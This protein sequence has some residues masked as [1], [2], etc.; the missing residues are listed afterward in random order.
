[1]GKA[2]SG[3]STLLKSLLRSFR[4][5]YQVMGIAEMFDKGGLSST[6]SIVNPG[7][8]RRLKRLSKNKVIIA[9][10]FYSLRGHEKET[11][12]Q[13]MLL[14]ILYQ[15]LKQ[16][17]RLFS[18][19]RETYLRLREEHL[20][21]HNPGMPFTWPFESLEAIFLSLLDFCTFP[22]T[23]YLFIDAV[24]ESESA[25]ISAEMLRLLRE[26]S[27]R[28][29]GIALKCVVTSRPEDTPNLSKVRDQEINLHAKNQQ[30]I[31]KI[32]DTGV[33]EVARALQDVDPGNEYPVDHIRRELSQ[34]ADGVVLWV[35]LVLKELQNLIYSGGVTAYNMKEMLNSIPNELDE[36]YE[37]II[38]G[39]CS[40]KGDPLSTKEQLQLE[41]KQWLQLATYSGRLFSIEE[42]RDAVIIATLQDVFDGT[43]ESLTDKRWPTGVPMV[44]R[45][46]VRKCG[47]FVE[48]RTLR[49]LSETSA[50]AQVLRASSATFDSLTAIQ[51]LHQSVKDFLRKE[52]ATPFKLNQED[53]NRLFIIVCILYIQY[54]SRS[55]IP[56]SKP[57]KRWDVKDFEKFVLYLQERPLLDYVLT[58]LP[59]H[60]H[61]LNV[62]TLSDCKTISNVEIFTHFLKSMKDTSDEPG[63]YIIASWLRRLSIKDLHRLNSD[64]LV[65]VVNEIDT[66]Y[67]SQSSAI[68]GFLE[69]ALVSAAHTGRSKALKILLAAGANKNSHPALQAAASAGHFAIA[70]Y[71]ST[72]G[73][74]SGIEDSDD[75]EQRRERSHTGDS[76]LDPSSSL[77]SPGV[78]DSRDNIQEADV[79]PLIAAAGAGKVS[80]VKMLLERGSKA[81]ARDSNGRSAAHW[82]SISGNGS[83]IS[84]LREYGSD[85]D[86]KDVDNMTPLLL[87]AAYGNSETVLQLIEIGANIE[88]KDN[89]GM[90]ALQIAQANEHEAVVR[91]LLEHKA[92]DKG[93]R[94]L[95]GNNQPLSMVPFKRS[96]EFVSRMD[97]FQRIDQI[98]SRSKP[99]QPRI[100]LVGLGGTG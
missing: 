95:G 97:I 32:I 3:K 65:D 48:V 56:I 39:L 98:R 87:A 99:L 43:N 67:L 91:V 31:E 70:E 47:G 29:S 64:V 27:R 63:F 17:D 33:H 62:D 2:G 84:L 96:A 20:K 4:D 25:P 14:S 28:S 88:A 79:D 93:L 54:L 18:K 40:R 68:T 94:K 42:F 34:R 12:H 57:L 9:S 37:R 7:I 58:F 85:L 36:L 45:Q 5:E 26:A 66:F 82:A 100:A 81:D 38:S 75:F 30:D 10:F 80:V 60:L 46:L 49:E 76:Q 59:R 22:L 52:E 90:T 23:I 41:T 73:T 1:V 89:N 83:I 86:S 6:P 51:L 16:E 11:S 69:T 77:E 8:Q 35:S 19:Y 44:Q 78:K 13:H 55:N 74:E 15:V 92:N 24:D 53:G 71:L 61:Q 72:Q 50:K 21:T